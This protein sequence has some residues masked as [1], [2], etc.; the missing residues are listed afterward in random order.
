MK[1]VTQRLNAAFMA[2]LLAGFLVLNGCRFFSDS[3]ESASS[4]DLAGQRA[5]AIQAYQSYLRN[6]PATSLAPR[7][8]YRIAKNFEAQSDYTNAIQ[9]YEKVLTEFPHT[10][11]ELHALLDLASLYHD[12]IKDASQAYAFNQR[13]FARYMENIQIHDAVQALVDAQ[14]QTATAL[15]LQKNYK[16]TVVLLDGI[17][18]TYPSAFVPPDA[19]AKVDALKDRARRADA[20]ATASVDLIF[21][22]NETAFN[23]AYE[24]DFPVVDQDDS[25]ILSPDGSRMAERKRAGNGVEYLYVAKVPSKGDR[26]RFSLLPQTF[27]AEKPI[28]SPDGQNLV[29]WRIHKGTRTLVKTN[30][31]TL[32]T[33]TMFYTQS[34]SLGMNPAYHPASNKIAYVYEG[35]VCLTNTNGPYYITLLKTAQ[36]LDYTADLSWSTDG[37]M[38]R[39]RQNPKRGKPFDDLLVLDVS[40]ANNP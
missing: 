40:A 29:Y 31:K 16:G 21:V 35:K 14:Y 9:W 23:K 28:W 3:Y 25:V 6:H 20:I 8:E 1:E 26:A 7:I 39:C 24:T 12:K 32:A 34:H 33:Q 27:G 10:D 5:E 38:I 36:K 13:A 15:F 18:K 30:V 19:L 37:T 4:M 2:L 17:G 22:R 11:E